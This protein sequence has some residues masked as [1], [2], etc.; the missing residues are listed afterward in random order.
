MNIL[1]WV[2]YPHEGAS[3]RYRVDQYLPALKAHGIR[4]SVRSFWSGP[5][6]RILYTKGNNIRK[7]IYFLGG[8]IRRIRDLFTIIRYDAV[9]IH[10]EA[11]PVGPAFFEWCVHLARKPVIFDFDDAI[12]LPSSSRQNLFIERFKFS[13]KVKDIISMSDRVIAGNKYLASF[14]L[15]YHHDV[16]VIPTVIDTDKFPVV[17][18]TN[19]EEIIIGW[20]GSATTSEFLK[21]LQNVF[22]ALT[23][24]FS[25]VRIRIIGGDPYGEAY[26]WLQVR[27]WEL[28]R[29]REELSH[30]DIG[31]MPMPDDPWTKGKCA[32]KAIV[33]MA[34][35]IPC[36]CSP[37]GMN[38]EVI[39]DGVNGYLAHTE[40]E[41]IDKISALVVDPALR[42]RVG[43]AGR[44]TVEERYSLKAH[45]ARF[46]GIL[47]DACKQ[48]GA[49][50]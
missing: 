35:G 33:Y 3:N 28:G 40:K 8:T 11:Y 29:E 50:A 18:S 23:E 31:I 12:F 48:G 37:V 26:P 25:N 30:I 9:F 24:R 21:P 42:G 13:G 7:A 19:G 44:K 17:R 2:P 34:A 27:K 1:F 20:I 14:A 6:F 43:A 39:Q 5:A 49:S 41:W 46:V 45:A 10:R 22:R 32:F 36:V 15:A 16:A 47:L 4:Y 38:N